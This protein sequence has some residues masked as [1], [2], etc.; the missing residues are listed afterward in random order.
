[1]TSSQQPTHSRRDV[2]GAAAVALPPL[3]LAGSTVAAMTQLG[4]LRVRR[5]ELKLP[6]LRPA[7]DGMTIAH[8]S[9][10]HVGKFTRD[11]DLRRIVDATN[12][13]KCDFVAVTG[14]LIDL[15]LADLPRALAMV[16]QLDPRNGLFICEGNHDLIEN[17]HEFERRMEDS[18]LPFLLEMEQTKQFRG[19]Q[20]QFLGT[21]WS[22]ADGELSDSMARV[23]RL[24]KPDAFP[25]LLAHHPHAFDPAIAAG[26]PLTLSG[27]THG[28]QIM[29][30]EKLG[31]GP[32]M[33]RYWSGLYQKGESSLIVSNGAGNWFP[34]RMNAP[35]E[36]IHLTLRAS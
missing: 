14:D 12:A 10:L 18:G 9:D 19:E 28:G 27:H 32:A 26:V 1:V 34:L 2:I 33:F 13:L 22:H 25:I 7:L 16:R 30:N 20:V 21:R 35:A 5:F 36:I 11:C 29:L 24:I 17:R 8:V 6:G 15:A 31:F 4:D 3:L 23:R